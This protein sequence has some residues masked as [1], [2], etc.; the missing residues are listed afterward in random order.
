MWSQH[1]ATCDRLEPCLLHVGAPYSTQ[2]Y[3][4]KWHCLW[5]LQVNVQSGRTFCSSNTNGN[6]HHLLT[7]EGF[8]KF[9]VS[10]CDPQEAFQA[11]HHKV[12]ICSVVLDRTVARCPWPIFRPQTDLDWINLQRQERTLKYRPSKVLELEHCVSDSC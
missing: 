11:R 5:N 8:R 2:L 3:K 10:P 9:R 6:T 7:I 4:F 1:I 12:R